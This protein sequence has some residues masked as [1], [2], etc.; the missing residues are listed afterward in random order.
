MTGAEFL[1]GQ[2]NA[3][4]YWMVGLLVA[5]P[6]AAACAWLGIKLAD[7]KADRDWARRGRP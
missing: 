6:V 1:E 3:A 5:A 7:W 2:A 4:G